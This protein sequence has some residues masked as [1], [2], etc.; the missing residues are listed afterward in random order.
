MCIRD[1]C[2]RYRGTVGEAVVRDLYGTMMHASATYAYLVTT[3]AISDEARRWALGKPI[4]LIDGP[5]LVELTKS[6]GIL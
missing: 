5:Q 1:R 4:Q 2:K 6:N 3:G